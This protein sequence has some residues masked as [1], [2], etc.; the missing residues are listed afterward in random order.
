MHFAR[1]LLQLAKSRRRSEH[2]IWDSYSLARRVIPAEIDIFMHVNNG[3]YFTMMDLGRIDM[4]VR[5]GVWDALR[6]RGWSGVVSAETISF[7]KS[8]TL[9]QR[10]RIETKIIGV[11]QR[12]VYFEHRVIARDEVY[13][14]AF[15]ATKLIS[16]EGTVSR[17]EMIDV[18]GP[19]PSGTEL[20]EWLH[21]WRVH[22]SLPS[23]RRHAPHTWA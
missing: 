2:G 9:G 4:M 5:S 14:R 16:G 23:P 8:L 15:V 22:N 19:P 10:Y 12:A 3:M 11:D 21:E 1:M 20:P 13:A 18:F 17:D 7:R 6:S